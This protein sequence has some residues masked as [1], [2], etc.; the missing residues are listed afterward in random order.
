MNRKSSALPAYA[1][2]G[3]RLVVLVSGMALFVLGAVIG[4]SP[5]MAQQDP[6]PCD[7]LDISLSSDFI[8]PVC[9]RSTFPGA[10]A[11]GW[12]EQI[13]AE[14][15]QLHITVMSAKAGN[16]RSYMNG[17]SINRLYQ[18]FSFPPEMKLLSEPEK[19]AQ[20]IEFATVGA[21]SSTH[22]I[23]FL[24][25]AR[26]GYGGY[27]LLQYG[28]VCDKRRTSVYSLADVEVLLSKIDLAD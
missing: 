22:C 8:N 15:S 4:S 10:G 21:P 11:I 18:N 2:P 28:I 24:R 12:R 1:F 27:R 3:R 19:T 17:T 7:R 6:V 16:T 9:Y 25:E 5:A 23:L 13:H 14:N 26:P 20:G